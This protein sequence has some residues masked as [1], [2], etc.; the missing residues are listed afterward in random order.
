MNENQ[1]E[2]EDFEGKITDMNSFE[3]FLFVMIT[4]KNEFIIHIF[5]VLSEKESNQETTRAKAKRTQELRIENKITNNFEKLYFNGNNS[6][7]FDFKSNN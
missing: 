7:Y 1:I 3:N 2:F 6:N 4:V 5:N